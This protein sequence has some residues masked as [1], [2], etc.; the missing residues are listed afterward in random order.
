MKKNDVLR[1]LKYALAFVF[2][3]IWE[4]PLCYVNDG[5]FVD[6]FVGG[7]MPIYMAAVKAKRFLAKQ[8]LT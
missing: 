7:I 4:I 8:Y 5:T 6:I 3:L 2:A 1:A